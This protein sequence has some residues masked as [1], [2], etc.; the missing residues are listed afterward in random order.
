M[1][2][3]WPHLLKCCDPFNYLGSVKLI[4]IGPT[5]IHDFSDL[6]LLVVSDPARWVSTETGFH[7][8]GPTLSHDFMS[9]LPNGRAPPRVEK[10]EKSWL[11]VG[12]AGSRPVS[13]D[14]QLPGTDT[15]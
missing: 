8:A 10:S 13:V 4:V 1:V 11:K 12:P 7:P 14:T 5:L 2:V 6:P 15:K 3:I 9:I